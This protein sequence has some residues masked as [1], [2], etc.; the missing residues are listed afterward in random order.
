MILLI[1]VN[2]TLAHHAAVKTAMM[3]AFHSTVRMI[4]WN[5]ALCAIHATLNVKN[6]AYAINFVIH[7][8]LL[9]DIIGRKKFE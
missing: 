9:M 2:K 6:I 3:W 8:C 1:A 5:F 4:V 7:K